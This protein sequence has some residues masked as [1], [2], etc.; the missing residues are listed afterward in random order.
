MVEKTITVRV[1]ITLLLSLFLIST[2]YPTIVFGIYKKITPPPD[3]DKIAHYGSNSPQTCWLATA[4]NRLAGA[5]YTANLV[6]VP[7]RKNE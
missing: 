4:A 6:V 5:G 1:H 7:N 3:V 2:L